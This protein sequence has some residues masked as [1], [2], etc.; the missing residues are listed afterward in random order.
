MI[1]WPS[2]QLRQIQGFTCFIYFER[3]HGFRRFRLRPAFWGGGIKIIPGRMSRPKPV[4]P[5]FRVEEGSLSLISRSGFP[6]PSS[7]YF[8]FDYLSLSFLPLSW[9][10]DF[11]GGFSYLGRFVS[12]RVKSDRRDG[13]HFRSKLLSSLWLSLIGVFRTIL[14]AIHFTYLALS[15]PFVI[16]VLMSSTLMRKSGSSLWLA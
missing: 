4:P 16:Q 12:L 14:D 1:I 8:I 5:F 9:I 13:H 3:Y 15:S 2:Y 10:T 6:F 11:L 7:M